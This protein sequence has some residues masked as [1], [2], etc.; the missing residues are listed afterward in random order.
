MRAHVGL[1]PGVHSL[2]QCQI[3][4]LRKA[5][6]TCFAYVRLVPCMYSYMEL[7]V[8]PARERFAAHVA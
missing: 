5:L 4:L 8:L 6:A 1:L 2:V 7:E 3:A